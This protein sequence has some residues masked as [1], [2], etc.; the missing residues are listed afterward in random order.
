LSKIVVFGAALVLL[1]AGAIALF[2][3]P[4]SATALE[5][6]NPAI[7]ATHL[8]QLAPDLAMP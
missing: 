2:K 6:I 3:F 1:A 8:K 4:K 5:S 7:V